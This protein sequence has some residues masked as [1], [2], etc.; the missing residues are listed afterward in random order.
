[1]TKKL[2]LILLLLV[3]FL[4]KGQ[5]TIDSTYG[6]DI[7]HGLYYGHNTNVLGI[8]QNLYTEAYFPQNEDYE[9]PAVEIFTGGSLLTN[10]TS[11]KKCSQLAKYLASRGY[12]VFIPTYRTG[13]L[14]SADT[15]QVNMW[16][17]KAYI[18]AVQDANALT[19]FI[20]YN[21]DNFYVD[22]NKV[23]STG[24]SAGGIISLAQAYLDDSEMINHYGLGSLFNQSNEITWQ[25]SKIN[26]IVPMWG[27]VFDTS[28]IDNETT[29]VCFIQGTKDK[30]VY[31][32]EGYYRHKVHIFGEYYLNQKA[33]EQ[34]IQSEYHWMVGVAHGV[35]TTSPYWDSCKVWTN[36]FLYQFSSIQ[37]PQ[38][39]EYPDGDYGDLGSKV[40]PQTYQI[41]SNSQYRSL[42]SIDTLQYNGVNAISVIILGDGFT[43]SQQDSFKYYSQKVVDKFNS[44]EPFKSYS[45]SFNYYC[46][47]TNSIESGVKH[48]NTALDCNTA[49]PSVPISNPNNY[50][51]ATFDYGG[52]HR[53]VYCT[54]QSLLTSTLQG[55]NYQYAVVLVNSP[56]YGGSG[57]NYPTA[58]CNSQSTDIMLH[59]FNH[60]FTNAGDEYSGTS[61][62]SVHYNTD[63][64]SNTAPKN[65]NISGADY[66]ITHY[67]QTSTCKMRNLSYGFCPVCKDSIMHKIKS[68][69]LTTPR[70]VLSEL[71]TCD[72]CSPCLTFDPAFRTFMQTNSSKVCYIEKHTNIPTTDW[73]YTNTS[74]Y[75][76]WYKSFNGVTSNPS[77]DWDGSW[78][79]SNDANQACFDSIQAK[80]SYLEING[81]YHLNTGK[82]SI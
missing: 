40:I 32:K 50:F 11:D 67:C 74:P 71:A 41:H 29:P 23:Y 2:L 57:G 18:R 36:E 82:D 35:K 62:G 73:F 1:M 64:N 79:F 53:L 37:I 78:H 21:S 24:F 52:I 33:I 76:T 22:T 69:T 30:V 66:C 55:L 10:D 34:G 5:V 4:T 31:W 72:N 3:P 25:T 14:V 8:D 38:L 19:R 45:K 63:M 13:W 9:R 59:E 7:L 81:T 15:P 60:K 77:F 17:N 43:S 75:S 68:L 48:P 61:C 12:V 26:A 27:G 58:T 46:L 39:I 49:N 20:K 47:H 70:R 16:V 80:P 54:N 44:T 6:Y 42:V 65:F 56:Y 51:G 28:I